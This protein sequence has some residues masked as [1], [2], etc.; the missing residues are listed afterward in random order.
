MRLLGYRDVAIL[1]GEFEGQKGELDDESKVAREFIL[2]DEWVDDEEG[3]VV[4]FDLCEEVDVNRYR[5]HSTI[6]THCTPII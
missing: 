6:C 3:H 5:M 1:G 2:P 4:Q